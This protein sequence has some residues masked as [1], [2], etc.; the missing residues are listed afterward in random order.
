MNYRDVYKRQPE[1]IGR[2]PVMVTLHGLDEE[3]LISVMT[4]PRNALVRQYQ[5]MFGMD[6]VEL[7]FEPE[8]L[9]AVAHK[10]MERKTGARGLRA[11][12]ENAM[13]DIMYD[14]PS[15]EDVKKCVVTRE[16]I[17]EGK[18]PVMITATRSL[19]T[20]PPAPSLEEQDSSHA[21]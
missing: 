19:P 13:M 1:F 11:I 2:V 18:P 16:T 14:I 4:K 8:A 6:H 10:A 3:A 15:R 12:L 9:K 17:E 5:Y 20:P 21:G 7:E